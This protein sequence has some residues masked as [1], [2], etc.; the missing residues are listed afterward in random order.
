MRWSSVAAVL[1]AVVV[2]GCSATPPAPAPSPASSSPV[3]NTANPRVG[4][5][6]SGPSAALLSLKNTGFNDIPYAA[7]VDATTAER[8]QAQQDALQNLTTLAQVVKTNAAHVASAPP[9]SARDRLTG[10]Y[11]QLRDDLTRIQQRV[12]QL[13]PSAAA[14]FGPQL[15]TDAGQVHTSFEAARQV[16]AAEPATG[17]FL[18]D[19]AVCS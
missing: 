6:C 9:S 4:E 11:A 3:D 12:A 19:Y 16:F 8:Q 18:R 15:Q 2:S 13:S 10:V 17:R 5:F 7:M 1:A 14:T